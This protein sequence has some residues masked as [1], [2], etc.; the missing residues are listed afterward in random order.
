MHLL[1][2]QYVTYLFI[3]YTYKYFGTHNKHSGA[4]NTQVFVLPTAE[5][6]KSLDKLQKKKKKANHPITK[7]HSQHL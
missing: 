2:L 5:R 6:I 1:I 3:Q 4:S 7:T